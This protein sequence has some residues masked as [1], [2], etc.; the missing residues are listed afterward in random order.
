MGCLHLAGWLV[1]SAVAAAAPAP[2]A[3]PAHVS[4]LLK[5]LSAD[6]NLGSLA[7]SGLAIGIVYQRSMPAS[8]EAADQV[9]AEIAEENRVREGPP[10]RYGL[11][12]VSDA[13]GFAA[14][15]ADLRPHVLF[16]APLSG[17]DVARISALSRAGKIRTA[18]GVAA[19]VEAGL[20]VGFEPA[21]K[22]VRILI[23]PEAARAEG[24]DFS[25]K[26]LK[27]ARRVP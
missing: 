23:N 19:F 13:S 24:A 1:A 27:L 21:P 25:S 26:V 6:R 12:D 10:V 4:L 18:T 3:A 17:F 5:V 16:V 8:R 9:V 20:A 15:V 22:G 14:A 2:G 11:V 7:S